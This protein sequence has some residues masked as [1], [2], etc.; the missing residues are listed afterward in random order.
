MLVTNVESII[1]WPMLKPFTSPVLS[2]NDSKLVVR[3][4]SRPSVSHR[5]LEKSIHAVVK[6]LH[7]TDKGVSGNKAKGNRR[8]A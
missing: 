7:A 6:S 1:M 2:K 4:M 3:M 5:E 8:S